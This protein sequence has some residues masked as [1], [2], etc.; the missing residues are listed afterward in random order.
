MHIERNL[1]ILY[2]IK[3]FYIM[4]FLLKPDDFIYLFIL[5][6][7]RETTHSETLTIGRQG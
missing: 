5:I 4:Q 1:L 7:L 2:K 6:A 3:F